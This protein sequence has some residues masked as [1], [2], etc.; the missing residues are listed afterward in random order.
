[1]TDDIRIDVNVDA[2]Q[3]MPIETLELLDKAQ[4]GQLRGAEMLDLLDGFIVGGVRGRGFKVR[5]LQRIAQALSAA[6]AAASPG[7][8][9]ANA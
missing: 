8:S 4:A 1:M 6:F 7:E 5:D 2:L 3:D 9:S